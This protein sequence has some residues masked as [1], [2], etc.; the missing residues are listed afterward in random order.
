[1]LF[2]RSLPQEP[3]RPAHQAGLLGFL[4]TLALLSVP[5]CGT[6]TTALEASDGLGPND[7][8]FRDRVS[9]EATTGSAGGS[10]FNDAAAAPELSAWAAQC[11]AGVCIPTYG[12]NGTGGLSYCGSVVELGSDGEGTGGSSGG[13]VGGG[14]SGGEAANQGGDLSGAPDD[15]KAT[16]CIIT[17]GTS[18]DETASPATTVC[19]EPGKGELGSACNTGFDCSQGLTCVDAA[20]DGIDHA[21]CTPTCCLGES[22]CTGTDSYCG[23]APLEEALAQGGAVVTVPVCLPLSDCT[24]FG[25]A[26]QCADGTVCSVANASG[27][28]SC[29]LEGTGKSGEVC[30]CAEGF[31][32]SPLEL[33]CRKLCRLS[34]E[35]SASPDTTGD[36]AAEELCQAGGP[37]YPDGIGICVSTQ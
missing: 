33:Q 23:L 21:T 30:P 16:A 4:T 3:Y 19:A 1:M 7:P 37:S 24:L 25:P 6:A 15:P 2:S 31:V 11:G 29:V 14:S 22:E 13:E 27:T 5:A 12:G 34:E 35:D 18:K 28:P 36:C 26:A 17:L 20:G 32:C 9:G 10:A 8:A